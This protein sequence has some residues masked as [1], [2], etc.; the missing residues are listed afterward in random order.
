MLETAGAEELEGNGLGELDT[1]PTTDERL[2][3]RLA[4]TLLGTTIDSTTEEMLLDRLAELVNE[5]D[6][7]LERLADTA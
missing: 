5:R 1:P 3:E 6:K 2:R 7:V 4:L